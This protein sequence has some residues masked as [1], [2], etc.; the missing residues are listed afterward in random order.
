MVFQQVYVQSTF[1]KTDNHEEYKID[2]FSTKTDS[3]GGHIGG[4]GH[5]GVCG[6]T[7][8]LESPSISSPSSSSSLSSFSSSSSSSI[9]SSLP[10]SP[11]TSTP[12]RSSDGKTG[13]CVSPAQCIGA[14]LANLRGQECTLP[15]G[16]KGIYC[17][18]QAKTIPITKSSPLSKGLCCEVSLGGLKSVLPSA[19]VAPSPD[20]TLPPITLREVEQLLR[21][22][23]DINTALSLSSSGWG[24]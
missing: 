1:H 9:S 16:E 3:T 21:E 20:L 2:T 5:W 14:N 10:Q 24:A 8:P 18:S 23:L 15:S 7:C 11:S 13:A 22:V 19:R 17:A 12:C 4:E 6:P